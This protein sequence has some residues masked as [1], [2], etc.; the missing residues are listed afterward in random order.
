MAGDGALTAGRCPVSGGHPTSMTEAG[1]ARACSV[2]LGAARDRAAERKSEWRDRRCLSCRGENRP[3]EL[4]IIEL[5]AL[6]T[7]EVGMA[8]VRTEGVCATCEK[9][10]SLVTHLGEMV[11]TSCQI[12]RIACK[13]QPELVLATLHKL[14][15]EALAGADD[16]ARSLRHLV[17]ELHPIL[18]PNKGETM[19]DAARRRMTDLQATLDNNMD[20]VMENRA[21]KEAAGGNGENSLL[22]EL[23]EIL[24]AGDGDIV[25]AARLAMDGAADAKLIRGLVG[26][27]D[28]LPLPEYIDSLLAN[29][30][31]LKSWS[32]D[33]RDDAVAVL[34]EIKA[35][36]KAGDDEDLVEVAERRMKLLAKLDKMVAEVGAESDRL[37]DEVRELRGR[38]QAAVVQPM[39]SVPEAR[40]CSCSGDRDEVLFELLLDA[41]GDSVITLDAGRI[42]Q[43]REVQHG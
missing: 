34:R 39:P 42:R 2:A 25:Q 30:E 27:D 29:Y 1:F 20:L 26:L 12:V 21:L 41:L 37:S 40:E 14:A 7:G 43:L 9:Q 3:P 31:R 33:Q 35:T 19:I 32:I 22:A 38:L 28:G 11:C 4:R 16:A 18:N 10:K 13:N 5:A 24:G 36:I 6:Q 8:S 23:R 17:D 15:P